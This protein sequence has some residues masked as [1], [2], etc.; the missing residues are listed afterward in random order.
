M[1]LPDALAPFA[2]WSDPVFLLAADGSLIASN[3]AGLGLAPAPADQRAPLPGGCALAFRRNEGEDARA[4]TM[5][6][7]TLSHEIRTPL[8]GILGMAGLLDMTP[9]ADAQRSYLAAIRQSGDHLL[10][11]LNNILDF[12]KLEAATIELE[13]IAF[14]P[15]ATLQAVAE[16]MSPRAREKGLDV[17]VALACDLPARLRGDDGRLRQIVTNLVSNAVKFTETGGV[18][19]S[20]SAQPTGDGKVGLAIAVRD[21][22]IGIP[23][24]KL[25]HVFEEFAQA[26]S[27]HTRR[28]GGT[29]LGL[30][31]VRKLAAAMGGTV[32]VE[33]APGA[34][35]VFTVRL[36][37][38]VD[39][40]PQP[41]M[42][43]SGLTIGLV[44]RSAIVADAVAALLAGTGARLLTRAQLPNDASADLLLVD[45]GTVALEEAIAL[46]APVVALL[47]QER[48]D[49]IEAA[50]AAGVAGYLVKPLR[51]AP[52]IARLAK[53]VRGGGEQ[54]EDER[55]RATAARGARVLLAEDNP[56]N[57]LLAR[58][59]LEREGCAV[60]TVG[61]GR[62][63][64]RALAD[65]AY[66]LVFLDLHMP[67][68]DGLEAAA[69]IRALPAPRGRTPLIALTANA[70]E[71]DRRACLDAGMDDFIPKPLEAE[72]LRQ[73]IA[74][75]TA[76]AEHATVAA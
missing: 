33:S 65:V 67:E 54:A 31:I 14:D 56:I 17:E 69:A 22:G 35:A 53:V 55:A 74:R 41:S 51:P 16:L 64:L 30:A 1:S 32:G 46:G 39:V 23:A 47:P 62:E 3:S 5:L 27:S 10:G 42:D 19:V 15:A 43:L 7:A 58:A 61:T 57:A 45:H 72:R 75:W 60:L 76:N 70:M 49:A 20:A 44:T 73:L 29:G 18:L 40:G 66:D 6:F 59:L 21:T 28:F 25:A 63:A 24:D 2:D 26:D 12:A 52:A 34:G 68:M 4:K 48:R 50:K 71:E 13:E 11:L 38:A 36:P 37:F 8:N 9:L